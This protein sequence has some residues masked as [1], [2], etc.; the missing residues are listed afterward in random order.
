MN[1]LVTEDTT[2]AP[3]DHVRGWHT[4]DVSFKLTGR[5]GVRGLTFFAHNDMA[6]FAHA[7]MTTDN[8]ADEL[9]SSSGVVLAYDMKVTRRVVAAPRPAASAE[10]K[11]A[12][13]M[14]RLH[15]GMCVSR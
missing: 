10:D 13:G 5:R 14:M 7:D 9:C 3:I 1:P 6:A 4:Y 12:A 2:R 11:A 8:M 15:R